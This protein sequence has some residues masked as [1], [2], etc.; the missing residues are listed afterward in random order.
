MDEVAELVK[1][2]MEAARRGVLTIWTIYDRPKDYPQGFIARRFDVGAGGIVATGT[3]MI[4]GLHEMRTWFLRAGLTVI[5][6]QER[7]EPPIVESWI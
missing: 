4:G 7:D 1:G 2:Q 6:R 3:T 5:D